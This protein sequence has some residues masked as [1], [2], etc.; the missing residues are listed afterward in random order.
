MASI[1][2]WLTAA[3]SFDASE[4]APLTVGPDLAGVTLRRSHA[5]LDAWIAA[6][7]LVLAQAR[8]H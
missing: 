4:A 3:V 6:P 8:G 1:L 5:W 7:D 2:V